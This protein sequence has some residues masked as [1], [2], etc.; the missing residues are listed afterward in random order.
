MKL[1]KILFM[2]MVFLFSSGCSSVT[3]QLNKC[4]NEVKFAEVSKEDS[5]LIE[6]FNFSELTTYRTTFFS[7]REVE[8][9]KL[10]DENK[11]KCSEL[12]KVELEIEENFGLFNK[13]I[14]RF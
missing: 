1:S 9:S 10:L 12:K 8:L 2:G 3:V 13:I 7:H 5:G 6:D 4:R 11:R 14:L